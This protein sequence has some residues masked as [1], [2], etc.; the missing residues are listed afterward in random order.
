MIVPEPPPAFTCRLPGPWHDS[1][2]TFFAFSP[3]AFSRACVA[4]RKSRTIA[5]WQV[6]HS[7]EPTNCAP[8]MLGG[9][10]IVRLVV[11]QESR[12]TASAT[13]PPAPHNK[14]SR[15]PR[16]HRVSPECHTSCE[17]AQKQK[18]LTTHFFGFSF[19]LVT[20]WL[21]I[22]CDSCAAEEVFALRGGHIGLATLKGV[23]PGFEV[24]LSGP[25]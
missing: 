21:L 11:L 12:M 22:E 5:S 13:A 24:C 10:R 1:Q 9:A 7:S 2:P 17:Y 23:V 18:D 14:L 15:L 25:V 6:P 19:Q 20:T 8:G 4:V 16:I 3:C